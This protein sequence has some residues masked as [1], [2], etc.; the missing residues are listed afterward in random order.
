MKIVFDLDGTLANI[1]HRAHYVRDGNRQWDKFFEACDQDEPENEVGEILRS[2][3]NDGHDVE[4]WSGRSD[5]VR[6]KTAKWLDENFAPVGAFHVSSLLIRMR[7]AKDYQSDVEL[8]RGWLKES[9]AAG[10]TPDIIFDDRKGV[11][12]MWREEGIKCAQVEPGDFDDKPSKPKRPRQPTLALMVGPSGA[13]KS[14]YIDMFLEATVISSDRIR[15]EQFNRNATGFDAGRAYSTE[16]FM[17]THGAVRSIAKAHL[18]AGLDVVIDATNLKRSHR[19]DILK[20]VGADTG[21]VRVFYVV[22]DRPLE[23]KLASYNGEWHTNE[24]II[25]KHHAQFQSSKKHALDGDGLDF[26]NVVVALEDE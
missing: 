3:M 22:V 7:P 19:L 25:R 8:K 14:R 5:A 6:A 26:V 24:E 13:G 20:E 16:G 17:T 15:W 4:I 18:D 10:W 1:E 9:I 2:L 23:E 12:D 11:V 21:D